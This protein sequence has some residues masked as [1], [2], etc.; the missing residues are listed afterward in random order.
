MKY[1]IKK[2]TKI[3]AS[4]RYQNIEELKSDLESV[5]ENKSKKLL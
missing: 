3:A 4:E 2:C 1:I 5:Y